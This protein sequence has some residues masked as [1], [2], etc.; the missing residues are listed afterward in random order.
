[1]KE[2]SEILRIVKEDILRILIEKNGSVLKDYIADEIK[3]SKSFMDKAITQLEKEG[4]LEYDKN[5][6]KLSN[7]GKFK[8]LDILE[9]H[10]KI[11]QYFKGIKSQKQAHKISHI[12]EHYISEEVI[13][14]LKKI[15]TFKNKGDSLIKFKNGEAFIT[16]M[17][18]DDKLF[19]RYVSMGIIPGEKIKIITELPNGLIFKIKGKKIFIAREYAEQIEVLNYEKS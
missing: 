14:N 11:E 8:A 7:S 16:N 5:N 6:I 13:D 4:L 18:S 17:K 1:M 19:E 10:L 12:I 9:K 15:S 2:D 3:V